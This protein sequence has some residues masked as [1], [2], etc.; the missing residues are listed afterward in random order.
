MSSI[1]SLIFFFVFSTILSLLTHIIRIYTH[2]YIEC[3]SYIVKDTLEISYFNPPIAW[4]ALLCSLLLGF[5]DACINTQ[6]YTMLAGA[7]A[8]NS[9]AAFAVFK[10][11]QVS[12]IQ[13]MYGLGCFC[14]IKSKIVQILIER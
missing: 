12:Q 4:I 3:Q 13:D 7:F 5:G 10:F 1:F 11:T 2:I 6:I 8:S 14:L 9:V